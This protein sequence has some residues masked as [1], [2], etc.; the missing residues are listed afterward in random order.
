MDPKTILWPT[1]LSKTSLKA[2]SHVMS[3]SEKYQAGVVMLYVSANLCDYFPAY[4]NYPSKNVLEDFKQWEMKHAREQME[5]ICAENLKAC[6][7]L[8]IEVAEGDPVEAVVAMAK[9]KNADLIVMV[10]HGEKAEHVAGT[11]LTQVA[12]DIVQV[13][14]AP[15]LIVNAD[16]N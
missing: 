11:Y 1:D 10:G 15:V 12:Q 7:N 6:P 3:L 16:E 8:E 14:P 13:A 4:G 9:Q 2:A 5:T